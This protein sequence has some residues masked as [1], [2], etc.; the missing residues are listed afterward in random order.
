M[1]ES[2]AA[3]NLQPGHISQNSATAHPLPDNSAEFFFTDPPYYD[4]VP[5][6]DLSD[7]FYVWMKRTLGGLFPDL[8]KGITT[9]KEEEIVQLAER[10]KIYSYKTKENFEVQM[11]K[12]MTEGRRLTKAGGLGVIVFAYKSTGA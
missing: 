6:A 11:A 12:A 8:F 4:S 5:Y 2:T 10:N 7:F 9:P 3:A 1:C